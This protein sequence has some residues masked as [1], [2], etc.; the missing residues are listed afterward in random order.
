MC[1]LWVP[2][3]DKRVVPSRLFISRIFPKFSWVTRPENISLIPVPPIREMSSSLV[4]SRSKRAREHRPL[5]IYSSIWPSKIVFNDLYSSLCAMLE[6]CIWKKS[7]KMR[8][9]TNFCIWPYK[10]D[11]WQKSFPL[12]SAPA[13]CQFPSPTF[14]PVEVF[15]CKTFKLLVNFLFI[16]LTAYILL[17]KFDIQFGTMLKFYSLDLYFDRYWSYSRKETKDPPSVQV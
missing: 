10:I 4:S 16:I 14:P 6:S 7:T 8:K 12:L 1:S 13:W 15:N 17:L 2:E 5:A 3:K 11:N 9:M